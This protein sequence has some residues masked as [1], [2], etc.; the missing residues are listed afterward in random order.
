MCILCDAR[1]FL[2]IQNTIMYLKVF[3]DKKVEEGIWE[4]KTRKG[5]EKRMNM[6]EKLNSAPNLKTIYEFLIRMIKSLRKKYDDIPLRFAIENLHVL[7]SYYGGNDRVDN[8]WIRNMLNKVK[9]LEFSEWE[10]C[11]FVMKALKQDGDNF[12][13]WFVTGKTNGDDKHLIYIG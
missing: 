12:H 8:K 2:T 3:A 4:K 9:K 5:F 7:S 10:R 1:Y 13:K 11:Y 6:I